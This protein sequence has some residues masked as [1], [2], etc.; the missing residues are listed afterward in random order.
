M[1]YEALCKA[2]LEIATEAGSYIFG[3]INQISPDAIEIKGKA[4]FCNRS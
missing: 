2:T 3:R 1:N 4:Q